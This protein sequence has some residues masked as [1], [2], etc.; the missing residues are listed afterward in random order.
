MF[1]ELI[2]KLLERLIE[3][4]NRLLGKRPVLTVFIV[5][6]VFFL[7]FVIP[8]LI[9][10]Y[11]QSA[12]VQSLAWL[13]FWIQSVLGSLLSTIALLATV[14]IVMIVRKLSQ[15]EKEI[16]TSMRIV[17]SLPTRLDKLAEHIKFEDDFENFIHH[18]TENSISGSLAKHLKDSLFKRLSVD[19][20]HQQFSA[21][22]KW[23]AIEVY[24]L[25]WRELNDFQ[26]KYSSPLKCYA[27]NSSSLDVWSGIDGK[28]FL[29]IQAEFCNG[30][31]HP[32]GEVHRI[33]CY[34]LP[35]FE[36]KTDLGKKIDSVAVAMMQAGVSVYFYD[37]KESPAEKNDFDCRQIESDVFR[38]WDFLVVEGKEESIIWEAEGLEKQKC[39]TV[40]GMPKKAVCAGSRY[41]IDNEPVD[42]KR[43]WDIVRKYSQELELAEDKSNE[44]GWT[45][46]FK[47]G[48]N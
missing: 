25:F 5:F 13:K 23:A 8:A 1:E 27:I 43:L 34:D 15:I 11:E 6:I 39:G 17:A 47:D 37:T 7:F 18:R 41:Y 3:P 21:N 33:L 26:K 38:K 2:E 9:T 44:N 12:W 42:L 24:E 46:K 45:A 14:K 30:K 19:N 36:E 20:Q 16:R 32:R 40:P 31:H 10:N 4:F 22:K 48:K 28:L 35:D 29:D